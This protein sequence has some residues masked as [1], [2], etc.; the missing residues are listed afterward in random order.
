MNVL[1]RH[2]SSEVLSNINNGEIINS[3]NFKKICVWF[4]PKP[5]FRTIK[6]ECLRH[7]ATYSLPFHVITSCEGAFR[8]SEHFRCLVLI[9]T[10]RKI[11]SVSL[12]QSISHKKHSEWVCLPLKHSIMKKQKKKSVKLSFKGYLS[13]QAFGTLPLIY[14]L[15]QL[16]KWT[17]S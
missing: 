7:K 11:G 8:G 16:N 1:C 3:N 5:Y 12:K 6:A 9:T 14:T 4:R 15:K 13:S 17:L 10:T 2:P